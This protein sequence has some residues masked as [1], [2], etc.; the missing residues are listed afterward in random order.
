LFHSPS[1]TFDH[2]DSLFLSYGPLTTG[3]SAK[4]R[5]S[6]GHQRYHIWVK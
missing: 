5:G 2:S 6:R 3:Q 4:S 1:T